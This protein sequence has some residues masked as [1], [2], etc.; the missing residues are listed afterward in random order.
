MAV[1]HDPSG[2]PPCALLKA[3]TRLRFALQA[4]INEVSKT[5]H[6]I[7]ARLEALDNA[8]KKALTQPVCAGAVRAPSSK[9]FSLTAHQCA[10]TIGRATGRGSC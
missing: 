2:S 5:A 9:P 3:L 6:T 8:N 7:K 1:V 10:R 4:D